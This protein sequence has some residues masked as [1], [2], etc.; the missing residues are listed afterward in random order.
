VR[1]FDPSEQITEFE[2][3]HLF[4]SFCSFVTLTNTKKLNL[5][6]VFIL[7]LKK[8]TLR[9]LFKTYCDIK[10]D[11]NAIKFFLHFDSTLYK[12]KYVMKFLNSS[13]KSLNL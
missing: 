12:S 5:A 7:L 1:G 6:N 8:T 13:K 4:L 2:Q 9:D 10:N 11:F 3:T